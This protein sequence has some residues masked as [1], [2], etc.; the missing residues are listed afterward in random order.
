ML[1]GFNDGQRSDLT[2]LRA[3]AVVV[4]LAIDCDLTI[5]GATWIV[6]RRRQVQTPSRLDQVRFNEATSVLKSAALVALEDLRPALAVTQLVISDR[7]QRLAALDHMGTGNT[8]AVIVCVGHREFQHPP[9]VDQGG[10][11]EPLPIGH[12]G[13]EVQV[14]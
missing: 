13:V 10:I 9:D 4:Y 2:I 8:C 3:G 14:E 1:H 6:R 12:R 5:D 7:P 11:R